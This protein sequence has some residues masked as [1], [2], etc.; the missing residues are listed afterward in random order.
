MPTTHASDVRSLIKH[1]L[2]ALVALRRDLHENPEL[3]FEE[4]R[5][6]QIVQR[7]LAALGIP[8]RAELARGT[9]VVAHLAPTDPANA[10][11]PAIA[12]RADMDAL[13][14]VEK[15]GRA[16]S[17]R[18]PGVMHA[19]GHDGHTTILL[20]AARVLAK[21]EQ[22]PNPVTFVFQPAE[23]GGGGGDL[24]CRDGALLGDNK[25]GLGPPVARIYGLHGWPSVPLGM[26]TTRP[27]PLLAA[28][29]DF[30]VEVH[31]VGG[32]AAY[33]HL[34]KDPIVAAAHCITALQT[35]VSRH[36]GP[37][38]SSVLTV[39]QIYAGTAN[40][41]IPE[42]ATFIGTVR[43]LTPKLRASV[44][45]RFFEIVTATTQSFGCSAAIEWHESYPVTQ[46]DEHATARF[47][48]VAKKTLGAGRV[49]LAEHPTMGGEDFSYY[50][51]H[52]PACFFL[53]GLR[54]E[55]SASFPGLHQPDFDFN[56]D[57]IET[58]V[59][60]MVSLALGG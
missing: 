38:E 48:E 26:V 58:G 7:E 55:H 2:E 53:L 24:M 9:G 46:N 51:Q 11:K 27:G 14:I 56:D 30:K 49:R 41:I 50:A 59:E 47:F 21:L 16:Y 31:G 10:S 17:S 36:T 32:H 4:K 29:D 13:P 6:S 28:V 40:N 60:M 25:G 43:T 44:K 45:Q 15:T 8:F 22:R 34:A 39:G 42:T 5:T 37:L 33:P 12:L 35:V 57:A 1:E 3:H 23:E 20:G 18:N 52:V 19:C 54:P